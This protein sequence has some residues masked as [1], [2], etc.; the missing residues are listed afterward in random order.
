MRASRSLNA[1]KGCP[2]AVK[3][4]PDAAAKNRAKNLWFTP[5]VQTEPLT[6]AALGVAA[7]EVVDKPKGSRFA[8]PFYRDQVDSLREFLRG[9]RKRENYVVTETELGFWIHRKS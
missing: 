4:C 7:I 2:D 8:G 1:A 6:T 3:C 5:L 9:M